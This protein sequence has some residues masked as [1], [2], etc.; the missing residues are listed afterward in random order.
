LFSSR[1]LRIEEVSDEIDRCDQRR[2][3]GG[4]DRNCWYRFRAIVWRFHKRMQALTEQVGAVLTSLHRSLQR[5]LPVLSW[6]LGWRELL[7]PAIAEAIGRILF[8]MPQMPNDAWY[9]S[10]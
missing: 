3:F 6:W 1:L 10:G 8:P 2:N 5:I 9:F 4:R 7:I